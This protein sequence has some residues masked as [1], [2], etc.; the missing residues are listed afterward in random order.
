MIAVFPA[1]SRYSAKN[2]LLQSNFSFSFGPYYDPENTDFSPMRVLN[3]DFVAP[4]RGF[5]CAPAQ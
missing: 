4:D 2:D 5:G 1:E 3:D